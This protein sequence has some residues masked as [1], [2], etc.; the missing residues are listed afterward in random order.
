MLLTGYFSKN[1]RQLVVM[2]SDFA[3]IGWDLIAM[4]TEVNAGEVRAN[5]NEVPADG[6]EVP[7]SW[8]RQVGKY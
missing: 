7:G 4:E 2:K 3:S 1:I 6:N 5:P 8:S